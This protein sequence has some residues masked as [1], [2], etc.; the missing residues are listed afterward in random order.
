MT[1]SFVASGRRSL[2][3][4]PLGR[5]RIAYAIRVRGC[6]SQ[7]GRNVRSIISITPSR[8]W[9]TSVLVTRTTWKPK[10]LSAAVRA[11][12]RI[13]SALVLCVTPST[14]MTSFPS[15]VMK[16][17]TYPAIACWRRNF[18]RASLRLRRACHS[19]ASALV[20]C[21][22]SLRALDLKVSI[23]LTRPLRGRPLPTGERC[24]TACM[25]A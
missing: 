13:I 9:Y 25:L 5:G 10:S 12:S 1:T 2:H 4:S 20:C 19:R 11:Q 3:L 18:H 16:S 21:D 24:S 6:R 23:P 17:T 7:S 22:L 8:F 14:S 15:N